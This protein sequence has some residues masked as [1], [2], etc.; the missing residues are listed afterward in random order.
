MAEHGK[1]GEDERMPVLF[2]GHGSPMNMVL[3]NRFTQDLTA[4][5]KSLPRPETIMVLSAHWLTTG[6]SVTCS[7][8]PG[9]IYDFS[10]FPD[11]LYH[12]HYS[13]PGAPEIDR[14]VT[15]LPDINGVIRCD[16]TR[17]LDH[18]SYAILRHIFPDAGIPVFEMSL[19]YGF[20]D[21]NTKPVRYHYE[22][23]KK[24]QT[25][26]NNG[27]MIIGSGNCVHNLR[28]IDFSHIDAKPFT[29]AVEADSWIRSR[30]AD[31][32]H[33]ALIDFTES[34]PHAASAAPTWDHYLPMIYAIALAKEGEPFTFVHEG[35]QNSSISMRSFRIG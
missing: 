32:D 3:T 27:V 33:Q 19:D 18:A 6:T 25:L 4:L 24:L 9:M 2:I 8:R 26:R 1:D 5:G 28:R 15:E 12:I 20:G 22:L 10:G 23:G 30:L 14:R 21:W 16:R 11:E 29:W 17:G 7:E 31:G 13:C 34:G 35:F